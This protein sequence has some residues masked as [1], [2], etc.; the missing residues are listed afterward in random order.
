MYKSAQILL[1]RIILGCPLL[2]VA[3]EHALAAPSDPDWK[4][5][6]IP[7]LGTRVDY[8]AAV[9][10]VSD[11][12]SE[13]GMGERLSTAD[14]RAS[15]TIYSRANE[16]G[17]TPASYLRKNL[18]MSQSVIQYQR[19]TPSFFAISAEREGTIYYSRCNFSEFHG[20]N[21][22]CFDLAYP[23]RKNGHGTG[24]LP[25]SACH[26]GLCSDDRPGRANTGIMF[27]ALSRAKECNPNVRLCEEA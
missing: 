2:L 23:Q 16:T 6:Q 5:F 4:E 27:S 3:P 19:V 8:P 15:L 7:D 24:L 14:R 17:E 9:F 20:Q 21:I 13:V 25:E 12:K 22:H 26:S 10:S 1:Y 18:R 11:G